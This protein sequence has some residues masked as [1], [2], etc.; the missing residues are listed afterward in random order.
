MT[1]SD[2]VSTLRGIR[3]VWKPAVTGGVEGKRKERPMANVAYFKVYTDAKGEYRWRFTAKNGLIIAV[4]SE[5][6]KKKAD[7]EYA[8]ALVKR[9]APS[10][11][12]I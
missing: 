8:I 5:S 9:D 10:A 3:N 4:S 2:G 11:P 1:S 12:V 7:C 6:Y